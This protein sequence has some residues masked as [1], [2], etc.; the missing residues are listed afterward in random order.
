V[1]GRG[2]F[3]VVVAGLAV[4]LAACVRPSAPPAPSAS[5]RSATFSSGVTTRFGGKDMVGF[6]MFPNSIYPTAMPRMAAMGGRWVRTDFYWPQIESARGVYNWGFYDNLVSTAAANG[7]KIIPTLDYGTGWDGSA[8]NG[9]DK[10]LPVHPDWFGEYAAAVVSRYAARNPG[11][12]AA[13]EIWNEPNGTW[14]SAPVDRGGAYA[15]LLR[16][17]YPMIKNANPSVTVIGGVEEL[18]GAD[19]AQGTTPADFLTNVYNAGAA[20]SFDA[21]CLHPY[22]S[23]TDLTYALGQMNALHNIMAAHGDGAKQI[24]STEI[25][26][27]GAQI[28][29]PQQVA[30]NNSYIQQ[31]TQQPW[32]GPLTFWI[33]DY[34]GYTYGVYDTG[35]NAKQAVGGLAGTI[36]GLPG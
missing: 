7:L 33:Q 13:V 24:Y 21:W 16:T 32:F 6:G 22:T 30:L 5:A 23:G 12:V 31:F 1:G 20:G 25:G 14:A 17:V 18:H 15:N 3:A 36:A 8:V 11:T 28:S 19:D 2:R 10:H 26:S 4:L 27:A 35:W 9:S 34:D 29:Q